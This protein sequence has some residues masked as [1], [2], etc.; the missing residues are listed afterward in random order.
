MPDIEQFLHETRRISPPLSLRRNALIQ[1]YEA[2]YRY[3]LTDPEG[4]WADIAEQ[5]LWEKKWDKVL[6]FE[7][8]HH[9]WF[10]GGRTNITLNVLDRH[11]VNYRRNKVA[12]LATSE[13]GKETLVTY[14]RLLRR[15]CQTA[16]AL[17]SIG[18]EKG[19]RVLICLPN[20]PEAVYAMLACA[21][22]GA[23]H[24]AAQTTLGVQSLRHRV[25]DTE[26]KVVFCADVTYRNGKRIPI[27]GIMD[28]AIA[29]AESVEKII[30]LRRDEPKLDLSSEREIDFHEFIDGQ[31]QWINPEI[32]ESN[33]PL[34]ILYTSGTSGAPKGVVHTHG[35]YM[36]G[37][38]YMAQ[39]MYDLKEYDIFFNTED[40]GRILGHSFIVYGPLLNGA[41]VMMREGAIDY[42]S[43]YAFWKLIERHGV[44][45]LFSSPLTLQTFMKHGT[46]AI[47][48][49][50]L[51]TLRLIASSGGY[52]EADVHE[53]VQKN[54]LG[55]RGCVLDS[56]WQTEIAAP[57]LGDFLA[58]DVKLGKVGKPMPGVVLDVVSLQDGKTV[59]PNTSGLLV[60]RQPL[61]HLMIGIWNNPE[62]YQKYWKHV[63]GCFNTGDA[64]F[65]DEDGYYCVMGRIDDVVKVSGQRLAMTE[66]EK[67]LQT[68]PAIEEVA[69]IGVPDREL[70]ERIKAFVVLKPGHKATD[71]MRS[72]LRDYLRR[73]LNASATLGEIE[74]R[75]T[76]LPRTQDGAIA[77]NLLKAESSQSK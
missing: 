32:V 62:R 26:A 41:T 58:A 16:N 35:G 77:H 52:L 14:D 61:P 4:F 49:C 24:V 3:A 46:E 71:S 64:A 72:I 76:P 29:N 51:S 21:R 20:T 66:I 9:R 40:I 73:E 1:D 65:Y 11:I 12:L 36:V 39:A 42:P 68:H 60:L 5:L 34:F 13:T 8:P 44:N 69:V 2:D 43:I 75:T 23:I 47:K 57:V 30:V 67:V 22:I 38:Y 15:V 48:K 55:R 31:P 7:P 33:H 50:D 17:K 27:K 28:D 6:E 19:D 63:P 10:I 56:W 37:T 25:H 54:V 70:G 45:I 18:V 53:W 59:P 74:F